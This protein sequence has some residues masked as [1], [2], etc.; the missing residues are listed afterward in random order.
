MEMF[1]NPYIYVKNV[2]ER[3]VYMEEDVFFTLINL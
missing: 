2:A 1:E 3:V